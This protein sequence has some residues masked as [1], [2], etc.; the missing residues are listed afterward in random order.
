MSILKERYG[1]KNGVIR[2]YRE[3]LLNGKTLS[4][5]IADFEILSNELKCYHSV[6]IHYEVDLQYFSCEV[7]RDVVSRCLSKR[8]GRSLQN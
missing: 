3:N 7:V 5:S 1:S 8:M 2:S 6:L 4:D